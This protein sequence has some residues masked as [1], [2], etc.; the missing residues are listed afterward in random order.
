MSSVASVPALEERG[1]AVRV[2]CPFHV[3]IAAIIVIFTFF[4]CGHSVADP[5]IWWHL[6]DAQILVQQHHWVRADQF[7]YTVTGSP[8]VNSEWLSEVMFYG[9]WR[10]GGLAGLFILY[11]AMAELIMVG[12]LLLA[13][14]ASGSIKAALI[15]GLMAVM[16]SVVNFGP[17]TILFGW[18]C[19]LAMMF[20]LWKMMNTGRAPLWTIPFIFLLWVN[21]HGSWLVGLVVFGIVVGAGM[22]SG[23]WGNVVA[24]KWTPEQ[25]KRLLLT[26][27][28]ILPALF[29]NPYG[30][31]MVW[32]P[33]DLAYRQKLNVSHIIE[34]ASIDFHEPRGK[35]AFGVIL[36]LFSLALWSRRQWRLTEVAL[37]CFALYIS[38]TYVRFM[39]P[40]AILIAPIVAR[41]LDFMPPYKAEIDRPGLNALLS[42][43]LLFVTI[44]HS[45]RRHVLQEDLAKKM[46]D[47]GIQYLL[48]HAKP[49]DHIYNHYGFGGYMIW[50]APTLPTFVDSRTDIFEYKGVLK[51]YLD[52]IKLNHSL[53]IMDK[54]HAKF[55]FFPADDP[56]TYTLRQSP[57]WRLVFE[58]AVSCVF[59]RVPNRVS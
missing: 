54:Y 46:P 4:F 41:Q 45:P 52:S 29:L 37:V 24:E 39:F 6:K 1:K 33:F 43:A 5:D 58:D 20:V 57:K 18:A 50:K 53:E 11:T 30:Y 28:A 40:A 35:I 31:K 17:R 16:M 49:S 59:E 23:T 34:W 26:G 12:T 38:L 19:F 36:L 27:A 21:F 15:P 55:V 14:R 47:G 10:V 9:A 2:W 51:D 22:V 7:S 42:G 13:W 48:S 3:M 44:W 56:V 25:R 32:Y 8:W